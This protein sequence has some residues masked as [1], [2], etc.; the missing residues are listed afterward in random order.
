[1]ETQNVNVAACRFYESRG[2]FLKRVDPYAYPDLPSE[3]Q[4]L[5]YKSINTSS[6]PE[7]REPA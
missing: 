4:F 3:A 5:W 7:S 2:F 1:M 6:G